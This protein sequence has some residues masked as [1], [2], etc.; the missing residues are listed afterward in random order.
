MSGLEHLRAGEDTVYAEMSFRAPPFKV[1]HLKFVFSHPDWSSVAKVNTL[2][3][4][5][6]SD[7][8]E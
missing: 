4:F 3:G 6:W 2:A 8:G 7:C 5:S 1:E